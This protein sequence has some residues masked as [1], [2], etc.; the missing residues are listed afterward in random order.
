[1]LSPEVENEL[2][3]VPDYE[4]E[5]TNNN[6]VFL[7]ASLCFIATG[8]GGV[9]IAL[10]ALNLQRLDLEGDTPADLSRFV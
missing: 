7:K 5:K 10:D 6:L 1:M 8:V 3:N 4:I 9:S 2:I